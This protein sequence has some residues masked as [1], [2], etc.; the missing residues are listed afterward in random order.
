MLLHDV[1][2]SP[3]VDDSI[4]LNAHFQR[5]IGMVDDDP[6]LLLNIE[7]LGIG[8]PSF[9][10]RLPASLGIEGGPVQNHTDTFP[11]ELTHVEHGGFECLQGRILPIELYGFTARAGH[12]HPYQSSRYVA[13]S[14]R[15][16]SVAIGSNFRPVS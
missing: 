11:V 1:P 16:R 13:F 14:I 6:I 9:I 4:H 10:R 2:P 12:G 5:T 3:P 15:V 8:Q 7:Y